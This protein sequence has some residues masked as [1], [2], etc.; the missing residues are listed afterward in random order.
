MT[1]SLHHLTNMFI[2][3]SRKSFSNNT[4]TFLWLTSAFLIG[5]VYARLTRDQFARR[6]AYIRYT[7]FMLMFDSAARVYEHHWGQFI[8]FCSTFDHTYL[9][10]KLRHQ[11]W[12]EWKARRALE[13]EIYKKHGQT[14]EVSQLI[15]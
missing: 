11:K 6:R 13:P 10:W 3:I 9:M 7:N 2:V 8:D 14:D 12:A 15:L 5:Y 1:V 4:I